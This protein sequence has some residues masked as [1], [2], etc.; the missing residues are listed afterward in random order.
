MGVS[1]WLTIAV[2]NNLMDPVTNIS[3][4]SQMMRMDPIE[5][6]PHLGAKLRRR[7][8]ISPHA[9]KR[10]FYLATLIQIVAAVLM[11]RGAVIL[12]M[13]AWGPMDAQALA[14]AT[15]AVNLGLAPAAA[16]KAPRAPRG[17]PP[18]R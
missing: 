12:L 13:A 8:V 15:A 4:I 7:A 14:H 1:V 17:S 16:L 9:H 18:R 3:M 5:N 6:A 11:W 2:I 10:S